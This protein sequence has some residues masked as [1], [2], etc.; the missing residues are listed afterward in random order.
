MSLGLNGFIVS[1]CDGI[2]MVSLMAVIKVQGRLKVGLV[3]LRWSCRVV[4][5][6][7]ARCG[8]VVR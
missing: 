5:R 7:V 2:T 8:V 3:M 1:I 4:L 6:L